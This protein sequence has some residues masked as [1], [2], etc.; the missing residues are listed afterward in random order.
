MTD[1]QGALVTL[2]HLTFN[3][4]TVNQRDFNVYSC[5]CAAFLFLTNADLQW[6]HSRFTFYEFYFLYLM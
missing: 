3:L 1:F 6:M 2:N 4:A 5:N